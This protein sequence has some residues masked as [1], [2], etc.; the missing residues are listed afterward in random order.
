MSTGNHHQVSALELSLNTISNCNQAL[1]KMEKML[2]AAIDLNAQM[3]RDN[4]DLREHL[5]RLV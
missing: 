5:Q 2:S 3:I 1:E 4:E